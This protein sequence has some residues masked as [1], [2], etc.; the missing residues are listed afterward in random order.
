LFQNKKTNSSHYGN[1]FRSATFRA[2]YIIHITGFTRQ[3]IVVKSLRQKAKTLPMK[4][5]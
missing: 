3:L 4:I 1:A 2:D 5:F